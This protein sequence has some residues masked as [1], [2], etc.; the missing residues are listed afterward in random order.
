MI[1]VK[2]H[3]PCWGYCLASREKFAHVMRKNNDL[4]DRPGRA[5]FHFDIFAWRPLGNN[6]VRWPVWWKTSAHHANRL[7][8]F[9]K[10]LIRSCHL[11]IQTVFPLSSERLKTTLWCQIMWAIVLE[12]RSC[13]RSLLVSFCMFRRVPFCPVVKKKTKRER[14]FCQLFV[15]WLSFLCSL[16]DNVFHNP[17]QSFTLWKVGGGLACNRG[18]RGWNKRWYIHLVP[19]HGAGEYI[20]H[21]SPSFQV[22][23]SHIP[24]SNPPTGKENLVFTH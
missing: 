17:W 20:Y 19:P 23:K 24:A 11:N 9:S 15:A 3:W 14:E 8:F 22:N 18:V 5:F 2:R 7:L 21:M 16:Q 13:C 10:C 6:N 1:V 12:G 4:C